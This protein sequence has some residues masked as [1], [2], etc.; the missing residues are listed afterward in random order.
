[1]NDAKEALSSLAALAPKSGEA[2][3]EP[4]TLAVG[5]LDVAH[6]NGTLKG[7]L[8]AAYAH[9]KIDA[10]LQTVEATHGA[11]ILAAPSSIDVTLDN[12]V[13]HAEAAPVDLRAGAVACR[14]GKINLRRDGRGTAL[15]GRSMS[16]GTAACRARL[17]ADDGNP[18]RPTAA[19]AWASDSG[20]DAVLVADVPLKADPLDVQLRTLPKATSIRCRRDG[21]RHSRR[22][23]RVRRARSKSTTPP[24]L[25]VRRHLRPPYKSM[26]AYRGSPS[27]PLYNTSC[28]PTSRKQSRVWYLFSWRAAIQKVPRRV[29]TKRGRVPDAR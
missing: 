3:Q 9:N 27:T 23:P 13:L 12:G 8:T 1:M 20:W 18:A 29:S 10:H 17:A 28:R 16:G 7:S 6:D 26:Q 14:F 21:R 22:V 25:W 15:I 5:D 19:L 24:C 4:L 11:L 2:S